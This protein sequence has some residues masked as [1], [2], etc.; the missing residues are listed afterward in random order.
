MYLEG[1]IQDRRQPDM[2]ISLRWEQTRRVV[3]EE[4][5]NGKYKL[6]C[7]RFGERFEIVA[8]CYQGCKVA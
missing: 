6:Q 7:G 1:I 3:T 2:C 4:E 8:T 5:T